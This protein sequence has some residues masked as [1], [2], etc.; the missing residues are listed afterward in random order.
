M[1]YCV[2]KKAVLFLVVLAVTSL[3]SP[4][5]AEEHPSK[6]PSFCCIVGDETKHGIMHGCVTEDDTVRV[7]QYNSVCM[8]LWICV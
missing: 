5:R 1:A 7:C 4:A 6:E 2:E 8:C 3:T